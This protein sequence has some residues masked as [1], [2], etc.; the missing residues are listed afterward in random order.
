MTIILYYVL[1]CN[2]CLVYGLKSVCSSKICS[3]VSARVETVIKMIEDAVDKND[4]CPSCVEA[5]F[6]VVGGN[7]VE[8]VKS[9]SG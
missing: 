5:I 2:L 7:D 4:V 8:N 3:E 6:L 9:F 1:C